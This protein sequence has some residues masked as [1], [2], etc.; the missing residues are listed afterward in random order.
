MFSFQIPSSSWKLREKYRWPAKKAKANVNIECFSLIKGQWKVREFLTF[1]WVST[2]SESKWVVSE[3]AG[4]FSNASINRDFWEL[5]LNICSPE[6]RLLV[7]SLPR[8]SK[9]SSHSC[10]FTCFSGGI[11]AGFVSDKTKCSGITVVFMLILA[12]PMVSQLHNYTR[13]RLKENFLFDFL[14][15]IVTRRAKGEFLAR[16][17]AVTALA[18]IRRAILITFLRRFATLN[19]LNTRRG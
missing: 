9:K 18:R 19:W 4:V 14:F 2:M 10:C 17:T 16:K 11:F 6:R 1:W 5:Q 3:K 13:E 7:H 15:T 8:Q 12:A